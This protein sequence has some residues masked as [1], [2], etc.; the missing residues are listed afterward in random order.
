MKSYYHFAFGILV[1]LLTWA[2]RADLLRGW[3]PSSTIPKWKHTEATFDHTT[4]RSVSSHESRKESSIS[5]VAQNPS[6]QSSNAIESTEDANIPNAPPI[7]NPSSSPEGLPLPS[8]A[9]PSTSSSSKPSLS[10]ALPTSASPSAVP[11]AGPSSN[12]GPPTSIPSAGAPTPTITVIPSAGLGSY[13]AS[14]EETSYISLGEDKFNRHLGNTIVQTDKEPLSTFSADVDTSSY[15]YVRRSLVES[16]SLPHPDAVKTEEFI[17]YFDYDIPGPQGMET[18]F[19][20]IVMHSDSPWNADKKV[21]GI[22]IKGFEYDLSS[23]PFCNLVFLIDVSGSMSGP[24]GLP[25]VKTSIELLLNK[26]QPADYVS[27]VS[28]A[29]EQKIELAPTNAKHKSKILSVLHSLRAGGATFGE[30]G[31]QM[32]YELAAENFDEDAVNR[33]MLFTDGDFNIGRR[34]GPSLEAFIKGKA[35]SGVFLSVFGFG[36]GR[37]HDRTAKALANHGNGVAVYID[38][39]HE[40]RKLSDNVFTLIFPI[41]KDVKFQIEFNPSV[42]SEYR[43]VGY[44]KRLLEHQDFND[45]KKDAGDMN[46]GHIVVV[47]Y[48]IALLAESKTKNVGEK[49]DECGV[50]KIRYKLPNE[51]TSNLITR[52]I[53]VVED[54]IEKVDGKMK[55]EFDFSLAVSGFA[56]LL[57]GS[58]YIGSLTY[59][60]VLKQAESTILDDES[61]SR[62]EFLSLVRTAMKLRAM[63]EQ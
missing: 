36:M 4:D 45:D 13:G 5:A 28:Y 3:S 31:L 56:Q 1:S 27:I 41:A 63:E 60:K 2:H 18:P 52:P 42:T 12:R 7:S 34:D 25:L 35:K 59:E 37:Y 32:A 61:E 8:N 62:S 49:S 38:S 55:L 17:N 20:T 58:D 23:R 51:E 46:S 24:D 47:L 26:L 10:S 19:E 48:E 30:G 16:R 50:L 54:A 33:V 53:S 6:D 57:Q 15:T 14:W 39:Q 40:A 21:L 43:L 22:A 11:S 9:H 29:N 44:E